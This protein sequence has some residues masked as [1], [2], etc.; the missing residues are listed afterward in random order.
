MARE[1]VLGYDGTDCAK[2]AL[3]LA[4]ELASESGDKL[5]IG[6]GYEPQ[7]MGGEIGPHRDA[8]KKVGEEAT[9]EALER[10]RSH[11][12]D[13]EPALVAKRPAPG[14]AGLA[15]ERNARFIVVGSYGEPPCAA[16]SSARPRTSCCRYPRSRSSSSPPEPRCRFAALSCG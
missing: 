15:A 4:C 14:L 1:I 8:L 10:A 13:A 7:H 12:V 11:G 3:E 9:A 2:A 6:Y 16:R 5:V